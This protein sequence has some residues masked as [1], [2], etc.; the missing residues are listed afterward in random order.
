MSSRPAALLLTEG[1]PT[2]ELSPGEALFGPQDTGASVVVLVSGRLRVSAGG[3]P[4]GVVDVP[5]AFVG[6]VAALLGVGRTA[7]VVADLPTTVR[8]IGAPDAFF[9][10]HPELA[11]ELARQLAGRLHRLTAYLADVREQYAGSAGHLGMVDSVLGRLSS[12]APV[13]IE[14]G[15]DRAPDQ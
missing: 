8:V 14:P 12:R 7:D 3:A 13:D 6:E 11:L 1:L 9:A 4:L 15:S 5:G 2:R 10:A